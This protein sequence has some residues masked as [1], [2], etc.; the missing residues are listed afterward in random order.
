MVAFSVKEGSKGSHLHGL[1]GQGDAKDG[2]R[3][4]VEEPGEDEGRR[5]VDGA[6]QREGDHERQ[7][8]AQVAEGARDLGDGRL[9]QRAEVVPV[10]P[11]QLRQD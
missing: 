9:P 2:A 6:L 11:G 7:Q 1:H 4:N 10:A 3:N 5:Q 8:G